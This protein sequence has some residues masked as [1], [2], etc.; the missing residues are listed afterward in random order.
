MKYL[1]LFAVA[2]LFGCVQCDKECFRGV[3]KECM[4]EPVPTDRMTL[5]DEFKYQID[6][7]A[8]VANK[9]NMPFK[10]D[11][12]QLKRSVTTL[13]SLDGMKA[14][15][16]TEKA[17]FKKSVNDKQCTGPL[18]EATSNL[19]TSE[20]FIRANKKVCKLFEPYSNCVEEKV[21]KNCGTA[22]QHLFD[23]I[24]KPFRSMSNSLCEELILPAD[25]KDSRPD[26]FGLLNI[27][28]TVVGV[29]FAS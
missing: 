23:W 4:R 13:C 22:A 27:Y 28:F 26:N 2:A 11:A 15:F 18:D 1:V 16:D 3:F 19:K 8:R 5:C 20:D 17:C 10:E 25:E 14:W 9:C 12:D 29:F 24:Y 21:E 7:V 6:C